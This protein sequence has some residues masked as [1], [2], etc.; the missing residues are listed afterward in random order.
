MSP[1]IKKRLLVLFAF[2]AGLLISGAICGIII[3]RLA[4][5]IYLRRGFTAEVRLER[6]YLNC[7]VGSGLHIINSDGRDL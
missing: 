7:V 2:F 4:Q 3:W 5:V 1:V 6:P